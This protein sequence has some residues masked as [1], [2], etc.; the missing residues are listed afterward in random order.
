MQAKLENKITSADTVSVLLLPKY[1]RFMH[2]IFLKI[3]A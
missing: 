3:I 2:L 1:Y